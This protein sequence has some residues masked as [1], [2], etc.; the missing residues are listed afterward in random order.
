MNLPMST[1][2]LERE[3][4]IKKQL[5]EFNLSGEKEQ[6]SVLTRILAT[7]RVESEFSRIAHIIYGSQLEFL[8]HLSGKHSGATMSVASS[9]FEKAK[10]SF[11][12]LHSP[13]AVDEW[14]KFL[15][16][17][18]LITEKERV[19]DITQFGT[20]FLKYLV[21]SRQTYQRYG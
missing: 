7:T 3:Q 2:A 21:D 1:S 11:P 4:V 8:V 18:G 10:E 9:F 5:Q 14:L 15:Y 16:D 20:D 17:A 6:I 19:I 12:D 13:H